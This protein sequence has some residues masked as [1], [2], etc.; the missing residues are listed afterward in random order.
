MPLT[1]PTLDNRRYQQLLDEAIARIK[2]STPEWTNFNKSDPGV[3]LIEVFAFL[4]ENLLYRSN[5]IPDRNRRK[6][7]KL[8]GVSL[9]P[10]GSA[11]GLVSFSNE[12]G[13]ESFRKTLTLNKDLEVCAGNVR[14]RTEAALD[15]LPLETQ[16]FY[17]R[18]R[19]GDTQKLLGYYERLY[20]S[21]LDPATNSELMLYDTVPLSSTS[22][23]VNLG[24]DT[25]DASLWIALLLRKVDQRY[26]DA[27][28]ASVRE[29]I[30]GKTI[31][32]GMVPV[33]DDSNRR[34]A[35]GGLVRAGSPN[36]VYYQIPKLPEGGKLS[37]S[38][39]DRNAEY[40][41][42]AT[43]Q[44]LAE[45]FVV[46]VPLPS[47]AEQLKLWSDL[48]PLEAG[49]SDFPPTLEDSN[50][51]ERLV[52]WLRVTTLS[53]V[54][55]S[56]ARSGSALLKVLWAGFNAV[57]VRQREHIFDEVLPDGTGEP[58]QT[59]F[60]SK[61][62]I[63]AESVKIRV[64]PLDSP[65]DEWKEVDDLLSAGPEVPRSDLRHPPGTVLRMN[66]CVKVFTVN[67][68]SGEI[69]FGDGL[70]GARPPRDAKV[71]AEYDFGV[72]RKGNVGKGTINN[73]PTLPPGFK[74]DNPVPTWGGSEAESVVEGEKQISLHL[75]HRDRLVTVADFKSITKRTPGVDVGRVEVIPM[76]NPE[77]ANNEPGDAPGAVT[78]MLIPRFDAVHPDAPT[79][80]QT[81]LNAVCDYL[82]TR[83][84]VTT[85]VFLR[86]PTYVP[87]WV[88][89]GIKAKPGNS[90]S[91]VR[92]S[93][94]Q[95]LRE[96]LSPLPP[97]LVEATT[98]TTLDSEKRNGWPLHTSVVDRELWVVAARVPGVQS[99]TAVFVAKGNDPQAAD[100]TIKMDWLQLPQV[101]RMSITDGDPIPIDQMRGQPSPTAPQ[102][103]FVP[104]PV[105]PEEC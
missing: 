54:H 53:P 29:A 44:A 15:V 98:C 1:I 12:N 97:P 38:G 69:R 74:V 35:P 7:L 91:E 27:A 80:D 84:L 63:I 61:T 2:M 101:M 11:V 56:R 94:K 4:M 46:Q 50:L 93:V 20:A 32:L 99:I 33:V 22:G 89:V 72:G 60:L 65:T 76:F 67:P 28:K 102:Q 8:L 51:N 105:I 75:Q 25:I 40:Q 96:F 83:R 52:T 55:S 70:R 90:S 104:V 30:A 23:G 81:F 95:A 64:T 43:S 87:I 86:G 16:V 18:K 24:E 39:A 36:L 103:R 57:R 10:A 66:P 5:Q 100:G 34:L 73:G 47:E 31:N 77:L 6:F 58:D 21:S 68:E 82:D 14:F 3:T 17:K 92:E 13:D 45:P 9:Q 48:Q 41:T 26:N 88:S 59:A 42:L 49:T 71:H 79:P 85:E 62:P 37:A 19:T 78:L